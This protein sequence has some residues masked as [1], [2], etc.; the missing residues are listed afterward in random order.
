MQ[1]VENDGR[2]V[3]LESD[4]H[5]ASVRLDYDGAEKRWLV[6]AFEKRPPTGESPVGPGSPSDR[7]GGPNAP[8]GGPS[9]PLSTGRSSDVSGHPVSEAGETPPSPNS[10]A[11]PTNIAPRPGKVNAAVGPR[12]R[13]CN[14]LSRSSRTIGPPH[15]G[16]SQS[17]CAA[18]HFGSDV[19][20][21][22]AFSAAA[23][24]WRQ[25]GSRVAQH[26]HL[27]GTNAL[28][29]IGRRRHW[30]KCF[31]TVVAVSLAP[32]RQP[33]GIAGPADDRRAS[34]SP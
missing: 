11:P 26:T 14:G 27:P 22:A 25:S 8:P 9:V 18:S 24:A 12:S 7:S 19:P 31:R 2:R 5:H 29:G 3:L 15:C 17:G 1:V 21:S 6:T 4:T 13:A 28:R 20:E 10:G 30:V 33:H 34:R 32:Q 23:R 16:H